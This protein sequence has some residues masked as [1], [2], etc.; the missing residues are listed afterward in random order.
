MENTVVVSRG[1]KKGD[2]ETVFNGDR[3]PVGKMQR[4]LKGD[5]D[6]SCPTVWTCLMPLA[7]CLEG[8][9]GSTSCV[10][11]LN[12]KDK[13]Q[14]EPTPLSRFSILCF[15]FAKLS[16]C[17]S[18][19]APPRLPTPPRSLMKTASPS[20]HLPPETYCGPQCF[21]P[22]NYSGNI[23][24]GKYK[25]YAMVTWGYLTASKKTPN[26]QMF[27][28]SWKH[29][30]TFHNRTTRWTVY[31]TQRLHL[32]T[33]SA[34]SPHSCLRPS[35]HPCVGCSFSRWNSCAHQCP[36]SPPNP[37]HSPFQC[38]WSVSLWVPPPDPKRWGGLSSASVSSQDAPPT[39]TLLNQ[40]DLS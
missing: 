35:R 20:P 22:L 7:G 23:S 19:P 8:L 3:V 17:T 14:R 16:G 25:D 9:G 30:V 2:E 11:Y 24:N 39:R 12:L 10:F 21:T 26:F 32:S 31:M 27:Y 6:K 4:I 36:H 13:H 40:D 37:S 29:K 28:K 34:C 1:W 38:L 18:K 33:F 15:F 5:G